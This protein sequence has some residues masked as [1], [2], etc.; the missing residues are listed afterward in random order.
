MKIFM[1]LFLTCSL[2]VVIGVAQATNLSQDTVEQPIN[3]GAQADPS[4]IPLGPVAWESNYGYGVHSII[5]ASRPCQHGTMVWKHGSDL[6][7]NLAYAFGIS[8][9][10]SGLTLIEGPNTLQIKDWGKPAY[11][12]YSK[13]QVLAATLRCA[14]RQASA[15]KKHPLVIKIEAKNVEDLIWAKKYEGNYVNTALKGEKDFV[16]TPVP[17]TTLKTDR[18]GVTHVVFTNVKTKTPVTSPNP[19]LIPFH[20]QG[21][22]ASDSSWVLMPVWVGTTFKNPLDAIGRPYSLFYDLFNP[23]ERTVEVN[24][25]LTTGGQLNWRTSQTEEKTS[26]YISFGR[27]EPRNLAA[28]LYAIIFSVQPTVDKPL[29]IILRP[30]GDAPHH[31]APYYRAEG[32][33]KTVYG[34]DVAVRC[35]FVF[36]PETRKL[37]QGSVPFVKVWPRKSR[38]IHLSY[39]GSQS[40][41]PKISPQL[42]SSYI[43]AFT[44]RVINRK[45]EPTEEELL[46]HYMKP[47]R[48]KGMMWEFW[49]AGYRDAVLAYANPL[50]L[51]DPPKTPSDYPN[52]SLSRH[53]RSGWIAG[54]PRGLDEGTKIMKMLVNQQKK[55]EQEQGK[56]P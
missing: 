49:L 39:D 48:R 51:T 29:E 44:F 1:G 9:N 13:E 10:I 46:R 32:W 5:T 3:L 20:S 36:D 17:N 30:F 26:I 19:I 34:R 15:T 12:P 38:R 6:E 47:E 24:S 11:S 16:P 40:K 21:E 33:E 2:F 7:Q 23:F 25:L 52:N 41:K 14:L 27:V 18:F 43:S 37:T 50:L 56:S 55:R 35:S 54:N 22:E 42:Q 31:L 4:S 8:L 53:R 45:F 28:T